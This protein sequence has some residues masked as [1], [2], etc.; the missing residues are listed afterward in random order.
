MKLLLY[1]T[2][3]FH[4]FFFF[5]QRKR[6]N[7]LPSTQG[8]CRN[9]HRNST[10]EKRNTGFYR[11]FKTLVLRIP[12][13]FLF[14]IYFYTCYHVAVITYNL[15]PQ[16]LLTKYIDTL[17]GHIYL[18]VFRFFSRILEHFNFIIKLIRGKK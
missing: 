15:S 3:L 5:N 7:N 13:I 12:L 9:N 6:F 17:Y 16:Q 14:Y 2:F 11:W 18:I 8:L 4:M 10:K 1:I